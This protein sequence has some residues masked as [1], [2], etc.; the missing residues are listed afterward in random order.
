MQD[1]PAQLPIT[2]GSA[3]CAETQK[4]IIINAIKDSN[5]FMIIFIKLIIYSI[6][7]FSIS[8]NQKN[9]AGEFLILTRYRWGGVYASLSVVFYNSYT[10]LYELMVFKVK[11]TPFYTMVLPNGSCYLIGSRI[12]NGK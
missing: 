8:A 7:S 2:G 1:P 4:H 11:S 3:C 5:L 10:V 12:E 6:D 9:P